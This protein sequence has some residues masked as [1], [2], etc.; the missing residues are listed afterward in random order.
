MKTIWKL[1][2]ETIPDNEEQTKKY[3]SFSE[4]KKDI[5]E[6]ISQIYLSPYAKAIRA[7]GIHKS[8]RTAM[9]DFLDNY[10]SR[11]DFFKV[12]EALPSDDPD[13]YELE[14]KPTIK[15]D[16]GENIDDDDWYDDDEEID[17]F[18]DFDIDISR[19]LLFFEYHYK[20]KPHLSTNM[21]VMDDETKEYSFQF[22][23]DGAPRNKFKAVEITLTPL[24][25][26][27]TSS[28]PILIL[29]T[30]ENSRE[31]LDQQ[32]IIY[33]IETTYDTTIERKAVGRNIALLKDL[34]YDIRR[35]ETGYYIPKKACA[36][37][38]D[39]FQTIIDIIKANEEIEDE[40][41]RKLIDKL[42]DF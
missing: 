39:D 14:K 7:D 25:Y 18:S 16:T 28:Y 9:A 22:Y 40:R 26:W 6:I 11:T 5:K 10:V 20:G 4:A 3:K 37:E 30:L 32:A 23:V 34:G 29:K 36:L 12:D 31:P 21:M 35:D 42:F 33:R 41:K 27:G 19:D 17:E 24:Q 38:Q 15:D 1:T 13:D 8:Y 2:Y